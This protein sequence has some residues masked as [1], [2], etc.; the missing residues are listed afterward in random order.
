MDLAYTAMGSFDIWWEGGCWEWCVP[1]D[2][3]YTIANADRDVAAGIA[4]LE[5]AGGLV[6]TANPP[7][8]P[9]NAEIPAVKLGARLY[10]AIRYVRGSR[11]PIVANRA[12]SSR[13]VRRRNRPAS[14]GKSGEGGLETSSRTRLHTTIIDICPVGLKKRCSVV[15]SIAHILV[16]GTYMLSTS[17]IRTMNSSCKR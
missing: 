9:E 6:T 15:Q 8:D 1:I 11:C 17:S 3:R 7:A 10:L 4:I 12:Q 16:P 14:T 2:I 13:T 5:E